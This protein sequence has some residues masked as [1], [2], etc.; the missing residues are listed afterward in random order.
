MVKVTMLAN[1][2][3]CGFLNMVCYLLIKI[4][5]FIVESLD[6]ITLSSNGKY[7]RCFDAG[8]G[9]LKWELALCEL[10]EHGELL[11]RDEKVFVLSGDV[12]SQ[13]EL[14][15]TLRWQAKLPTIQGSWLQLHVTEDG[16]R[17]FVT[18]G[19]QTRSTSIV[20]VNAGDG[21]LETQTLNT[22]SVWFDPTRC[23]R[24]SNFFGCIGADNK[25]YHLSVGSN[26]FRG[27]NIPIASEELAVPLDVDY[28]T[29]HIFVRHATG[30]VA[31]AC[32][33]G[34][35]KE[36]FMKPLSK[37]GIEN[38]G[39]GKLLKFAS[40][41]SFQDTVVTVFRDE[42]LFTKTDDN[43]QQVTLTWYDE[44]GKEKAINLQTIRLPQA[45]P[46]E[47]VDIYCILIKVF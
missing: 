16:S 7:L 2:D 10:C 46:L 15:G 11:V 25:F 32:E 43:W 9:S 29:K 18:G 36:I 47:K 45:V 27:Y 24:Y 28:K 40:E 38:N 26:E 39:N 30:V 13:V 12:V 6:L 8:N 3:S 5:N 37:V 23:V 20:S 33:N 22:A 41:I 44:S 17:A 4:C 34:A 21:S 1:V 31:F 35:M 19:L 14:D 42:L